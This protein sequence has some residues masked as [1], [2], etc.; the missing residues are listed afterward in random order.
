[1]ISSDSCEKTVDAMKLHQGP[2]LM[3]SADERGW[4]PAY[5]SGDQKLL[6]LKGSKRFGVLLTSKREKPRQ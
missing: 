4:K 2:H 6:A 5:S 1:M 3:Y